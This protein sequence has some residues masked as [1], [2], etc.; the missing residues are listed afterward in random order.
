MVEGGVFRP[1]P[2]ETPLGVNRHHPYC[3]FWIFKHGRNPIFD[4]MVA[5]CPELWLSLVPRTAGYGLGFP[6]IR[7]GSGDFTAV[8]EVAYVD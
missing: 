6:A 5:F 3:P 8:L 2:S 7:C 4:E 1:I